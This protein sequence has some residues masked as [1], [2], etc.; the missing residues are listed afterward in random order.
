MAQAVEIARFRDGEPLQ[1]CIEVLN[2]A[3]ISH[4]VSSDA[5]VFDIMALGRERDSTAFIMV[6]P[7]EGRRAREALLAQARSDTASESLSD[8][9]FDSF[10]D[11]ELLDVV[12][13]PLEWSPEDVA[14][15]E[16]LLTQRQMPFTPAVY[17]DPEH[18]E[19]EK[20]AY[21]N[22]SSAEPMEPG[23]VAANRM[24]IIAGYIFGLGIISLIIGGS[25]YFSTATTSDGR[26]TYFYDAG[27][28]RHGL[29]LLLFSFG[30]MAIMTIVFRKIGADPH[31]SPYRL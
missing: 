6:H 15:A 4:R 26:K 1:H 27:S 25:L 28:R 3:G 20:E 17:P 16:V 13:W 5:P 2:A 23:T 7:Q 24:L 29:I 10:S 18:T 11:K 8:H 9:H 14:T 12:K 19:A 30:W 21:R 22:A 31:P